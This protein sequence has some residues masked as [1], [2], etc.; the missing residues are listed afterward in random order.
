MASIELASELLLQSQCPDWAVQ[1]AAP[2]QVSKRCSAL[3]AW[4]L[5]GTVGS[6]GL[7]A[8]VL[9]LL[10][11]GVE[12]APMCSSAPCEQTGCEHPSAARCLRCC[13]CLGGH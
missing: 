9:C 2:C 12:A 8:G 4:S 3:S 7:Q 5:C 13:S 10:C 6:G 11:V 1:G